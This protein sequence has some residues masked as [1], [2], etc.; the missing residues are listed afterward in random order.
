MP[1]FAGA[2]FTMHVKHCISMVK[3]RLNFFRGMACRYS[4]CGAKPAF[5]IWVAVGVYASEEWLHAYFSFQASV[6]VQ[7]CTHAPVSRTTHSTLGFNSKNFPILGSGELR[8]P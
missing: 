6:T 5:E 8:T 3:S 2:D 7:L 4:F 1:W